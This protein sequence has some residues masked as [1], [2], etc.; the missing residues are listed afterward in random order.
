MESYDPSAGMNIAQPNGPKEKIM[1]FISCRA[2]KD[3]DYIGKSDPYCQVFLKNDERSPWQKIAK[4]DTVEN[5]LN[6]D[7]STPIIVEYFFEKTQL[8]RFE[9]WDQDPSRSEEQGSH[10]C[11]VSQLIAAKNQTYVTDLSHSKKKGSQGKLI[12]R[13]DAVKE[14]N[15]SVIMTLRATGLKPKKKMLIKSGNNPFLVIKR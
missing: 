3:L 8:I 9:V 4:T 5:N 13:T 2:L 6:P 7:F 14:S 10:T 15:Q 12:V 1:L 11:K